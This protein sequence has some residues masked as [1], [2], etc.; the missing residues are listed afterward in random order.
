MFF[1][2]VII[3]GKKEFYEGYNFYD[4]MYGILFK[5]LMIYFLFIYMGL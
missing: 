2:F 5:N 3:M 1:V 4:E